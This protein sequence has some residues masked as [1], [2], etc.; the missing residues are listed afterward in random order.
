VARKL[1][2]GSG[3]PARVADH[4]SEIA[5]D[6]DGLVAE[7]LELPELPQDDRVTKVEVGAR[8][9]HAEFHAQRAP[10]RELC[11]QFHLAN[12]LSGALLENGD[13]FVRLHRAR[14]SPVAGCYLLLFNNS[15]TCSIVSGLFCAESDFWL[16]PL[17]RNGRVPA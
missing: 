8:R 4:G 16:L 2:P 11:P 14:W 3:P 17:S 13:G 5:D 1:G 7:I 9:I 6:E 12:D 10:E 15:R